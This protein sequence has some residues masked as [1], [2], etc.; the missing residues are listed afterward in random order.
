M[1]S[2]STAVAAGKP[3]CGKGDSSLP[4]CTVIKEKGTDL[5]SEDEFSEK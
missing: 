1:R 4:P 2:A 5:F 3:I